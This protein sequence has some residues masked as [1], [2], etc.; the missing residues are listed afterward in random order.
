[1]SIK[2]IDIIGYSGTGKTYFIMN[3]IKLFKQQLSYNV[4]V[5]KNVKHHQIDEKGKDSYIFTETGA[6][7]SLIKNNNNDMGIFLNTNDLP[8]E[9][10]ISWLQKGPDKIDLLLTEGFRNLNNPTVLC[11]S[12]IDHIEPQLNKNIKMISGIICNNIS[13]EKIIRDFPIVDIEKDFQEFRK[14]FGI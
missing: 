4:A 9:E 1:M 3:A 10:I 2:I 12:S 6:S 8:I 13:E 7:Y 5:I 11:I 14:I